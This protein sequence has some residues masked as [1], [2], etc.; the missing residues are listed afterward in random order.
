MSLSD[1]EKASATQKEKR[2]K[3]M[4]FGTASRPS[5]QESPSTEAGTCASVLWSSGGSGLGALYAL[6]GIGG[7]GR[8][9][10]LAASRLSY[11]GFVA[12][13]D[14]DAAASL[15]AAAVAAFA[16]A[17][18]APTPQHQPPRAPEVDALDLMSELWYELRGKWCLG[19][20]QWRRGHVNSFLFLFSL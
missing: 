18:P 10:S 12:A 14:A 2:K 9:G 16:P 17:L 3:E 20:G 5:L 1:S 8:G 4:D 7:S 11:A 19:G 15:A 13:P 6:V